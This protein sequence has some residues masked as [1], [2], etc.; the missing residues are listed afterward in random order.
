MG[1]L[2]AVCTLVGPA[3]LQSANALLAACGVLLGGLMLPLCA[4][5]WRALSG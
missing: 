1:N 4:I 5:R 2:T 3:L